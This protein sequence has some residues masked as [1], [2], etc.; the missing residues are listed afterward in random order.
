MDRQQVDRSRDAA[1]GQ[2]ITRATL[3]EQLEEALRADILDGVL[4]PGRRLRATELS[5]RY[6]V[7][8]TPLR[9]ALQRLAVE[10][11]V[12]LDPR[13]GARVAPI[14]E[15][16]LRDV[17]EQLTLVGCLALERSIRRGD[18]AWSAELERCCRLLSDAT[19]RQEAARQDD[20]A[21]RRRLGIELAT[22]HWDFHNALYRACGSP[23]L[24]RF[25][26]MLHAHSE[27]YRRLALHAAGMRRDLQ[28][29]HEEIMEASQRRDPDAAVARLRQH[30]E[31]TVTLLLEAFGEE[32]RVKD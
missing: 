8:A 6:G 1:P 7:S 23:W 9:E 19:A 4:E 17:Y 14:S 32:A 2:R 25:V 26:Q 13:Y 12:E 3:T 30:L 16:D 10:N 11:L 21:T 18:D 5:G 31:T 20:D 15:S 29:E 28:H 27:R 24:L 22:A